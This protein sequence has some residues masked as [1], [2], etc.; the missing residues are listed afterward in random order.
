MK[1]I[2]MIPLILLMTFFSLGNQIN[3]TL[4]S[5]AW[6]RDGDYLYKEYTITQDDILTT[7]MGQIMYVKYFEISSPVNTDLEYFDYTLLDYNKVKHHEGF[8]NNKVYLGVFWNEG[9]TELPGW[10]TTYSID[11][12]L[13]GNGKTFGN[14]NQGNANEGSIK[15]TFRYFDPFVGDVDRPPIFSGPQRIHNVIEDNNTVSQIIKK[16]NITAYDL[17]DGD[18]TEYIQIEHDEYSG[19]SQEIGVYKVILKVKNSLDLV[20]YYELRISNEP[21]ITEEEEGKF[22]DDIVFT[23]VEDLPKTPKGLIPRV[24]FKTEGYS[25][26]IQIV[27][28]GRAFYL[29]YNFTDEQDMSLFDTVE[30]YFLNIDEPQIIINHSDRPYLREILESPNNESPAFVPHSI[31]DLNTNEIET[32]LKYAANVY[33]KNNN[34]GVM[35]SYVYID[36]FIMD[37]IIST[38][39]SWTSRV[40]KSVLGINAGYTDWAVQDA[41]FTNS[42]YLTY[43]NKSASWQNYVPGWNQVRNIYQHL[44][45]YEMPRIASV[46]LDNPQKDYNV[47][48]HELDRYF[49][50]VNPDF[51]EISKDKRFKV[52]AFALEPEALNEIS[53]WTGYIYNRTTQFYD[54]PNDPKD[55]YNFQIININYITNGKV[56]ETIGDDMNIYIKVDEGLLPT[57]NEERTILEKAMFWAITAVIVLIANGAGF[58]K[59]KKRRSWAI[60]LKIG[61]T[62]GAIFLLWTWFINFKFLFK[63]AAIVLR[64]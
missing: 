30:S 19:Q 52:W 14:Y 36:E 55:P 47:T 2:L 28:S 38:T 22:P 39:L 48:R 25:L 31:W 49:K 45:T 59:D 63:V 1:K 27:I 56:Y 8:T 24:Y 61:L 23:E 21:K 6:E 64:L 15:V 57:E 16:A 41:V 18:L 54:N 32:Q 35:I 44:K 62:V 26:K 46:N 43:K 58:F 17:I 53:M 5:T 40:K 42:D 37:Q 4:E 9:D 12:K 50:E 7:V 10:S 3:P 11:G 13:F 60:A 29:K 51:D 34:H 33:I 20:S